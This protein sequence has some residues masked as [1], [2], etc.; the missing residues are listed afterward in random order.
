MDKRTELYF[1]E[2]LQGLEACINATRY[3]STE[4]VK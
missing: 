2:S 3:I 4:L 1:Y